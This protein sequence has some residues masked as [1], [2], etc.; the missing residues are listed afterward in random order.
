MS[1]QLANNAHTFLAE[2]INSIVTSFTVES[3]DSF[4]TLGVGDYFYCTLESTSGLYEI[5]KVTAIAGFTFT[6]V[7]GQE[8]TVAVPF[9]S[10]A[11]VELR[12]TVQNLEDQIDLQIDTAIMALDPLVDADIGV[13]VQGYDADLAALAANS[14]NGLLTRTGAG[15]VA[16]RTITAGINGEVTVANGDGVAGNPTVS[17]TNMDGPISE[18]AAAALIE[19][20]VQE[21]RAAL[22]A[23]PRISI[24]DY[25]NDPVVIAAILTHTQTADVATYLQAACD[26]ADDIGAGVNCPAGTYPILSTVTTRGVSIIGEP[27]IEDVYPYGSKGTVFVHTSTTNTPFKLGESVV[28]K[29][30]VFFW[31]DQIESAATW[32]ANSN[33][34]IVYP[35]LIENINPTTSLVGFGFIDNVVV[36]AYDFM[37]VGGDTAFDKG[38]RWAFSGNRVCALRRVFNLDNIPDT[39]MCDGSNLWGWNVFADPLMHFGSSAGYS[40]ATISVS[41]ITRSS[42]TA[43]VTTAVSHGLATGQKATIAGATQTDYNGSY[44]ITVTGAT[45]FTYT[46]A[47]SPATPATG[48]ITSTAYYLRDYAVNNSTM[49]RVNGDAS[50]GAAAT[51]SVDGFLMGGFHWGFRK[52]IDIDG[53]KL[54]ILNTK[55]ASFDGCQ[56]LIHTHN[57][58]NIASADFDMGGGAFV[59]KFNY[60]DTATPPAFEID[61]PAPQSGAGITTLRIRGNMGFCCGTFL[62]ATGDYVRSIDVD[63][64]VNVLAHLTTDAGTYYAADINCPNARV[65]V[66]GSFTASAASTGS[67]VRTG[68]RFVD[69]AQSNVSGVM[70][71][72]LTRP[73]DITD[74]AGAYV[75]SGCSSLS[76]ADTY[77]LNS[78][79]ANISAMGNYFDK[80]NYAV[81]PMVFTR[82]ANAVNGIDVRG[83][84]ASSAA[85]LTTTGADTNIIMQ[86]DTKGTDDFGSAIHFRPG[87]VLGALV[88]AT[89]SAVNYLAIKPGATG[90]NVTLAAGGTDTNVNLL[91]G[92]QGTGSVLFAANA[93]PITTQALGSTTRG[94]TGLHLAT[95]SAF[96]IANG[97]WVATHSSGILTV[98]TGDLR[99]TNAGTNAAS[100]VTVDGIQTLNNKTLP[101]A[102]FG[103]TS[104]AVVGISFAISNVNFNSANTDNAINISLPTGFTRYRVVGL[105]LD[106]PSQTLTTAT[107]GLFTATAAGGTAVVASGS[108]ITVSTAAANTNNNM[109]GFTIVN[110]NTTAYSVSSVPTLY[111]RVQNPQGAAATGS[112][113]VQ[114]QPIP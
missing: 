69:S 107:C 79:T 63:A 105:Q 46:V 93:E 58:G 39:I 113:T 56:Q 66:K 55:D 40:G 70:F 96:N 42:T 18:A 17:I 102:A 27:F 52:V 29:D 44:I 90:S 50:V 94:W 91:V 54:S 53:G 5:V 14:T 23:G 73:V 106:N 77:S 76:T 26:A 4:P 3:I 62:K 112:V 15:T 65:S 110:P 104:Y 43:T 59:N 92:A 25:I 38:G 114:I 2:D 16:A 37:D 32:V 41:S 83:G 87:G 36:N 11:R 30:I 1:I 78:A 35:P 12:V 48:T 21:I 88:R 71:T 19:T 80:R 45:T 31:P 95:G 100:V 75:V 74:T 8:G 9:A 24:L 61:T 10:G 64:T 6:I 68:L 47:N 34:P 84:V 99:V 109:M 101:V 85:R 111:F 103:S 98:G 57:Y 81:E 97:N 86:L 72:A 60:S 28:F 108:A 13:T 20:T 33:G 51:Y 49:L 82:N 89:A 22:N 67:V 7:R